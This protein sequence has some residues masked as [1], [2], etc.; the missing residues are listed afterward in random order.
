MWQ[1]SDSELLQRTNTPQILRVVE[2]EKNDDVK[3][4]YIK[5]LMTK[6]LSFPHPHRVPKISTTTIFS[7]QRPST[8]N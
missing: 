7:A 2:L 8:N 4:P 6:K 1:C 3:R 5:Q